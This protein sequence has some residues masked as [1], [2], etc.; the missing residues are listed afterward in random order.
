MK[1]AIIFFTLL[2]ATSARCI[3]DDLDDDVAISSATNN[4]KK[5]IFEANPERVDYA[6]LH[7]NVRS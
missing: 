7:L 6:E 2:L 3:E 5:Y 1:I 4:D